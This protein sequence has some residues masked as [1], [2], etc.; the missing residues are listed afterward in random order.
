MALLKKTYASMIKI[1]HLVFDIAKE[2]RLVNILVIPKR[3]YFYS[4]FHHKAFGSG[5]F[6][7]VIL[8][9]F[10]KI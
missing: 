8:F 9:R 5:G 3:Q 4:Q 6:G 1:K 2:L 7:D 10:Y